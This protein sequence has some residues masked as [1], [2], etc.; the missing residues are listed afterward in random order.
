M[1]NWGTPN[2]S[3]IL[4]SLLAASALASIAPCWA[5][6]ASTPT[7]QDGPKCLYGDALPENSPRSQQAQDVA[8]R[9]I[10]SDFG[11]KSGDRPRA[12]VCDLVDFLIVDY[13]PYNAFGLVEWATVD[14]KTMEIRRIRLSEG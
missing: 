11:W 8:W 1:G 4:L 9:Q 12:L 2:S 10:A 3:L 13:R 6:D 7:R 14:A 5:E